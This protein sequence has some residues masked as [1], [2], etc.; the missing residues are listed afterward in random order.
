M[1]KSLLASIAFVALSA[2]GSAWAAD[3]PVK[4]RPVVPAWTWNGC[5]VGLNVGYANARFRKS[6]VVRVFPNPVTFA[7]FDFD[8][9]GAAGGAQIGCNWQTGQTVFGIETD[10][11]VTSIEARR[12]FDNAFFN[13][14]DPDLDTDVHSSLRYFGTVR[15]RLGWTVTPTT[16][17][18][19]T[20]GFAYGRV[21]SS[22]QILTAAGAN[23]G[24][25]NFDHQYHYG[26]AVGAGGEAKVAENFTAKLEYLYV[27]L[28]S[29]DYS[30]N[31]FPTS[32]L[33][34]G[35]KQRVDV[36]TIRLGLNYQFDW[37]KPVVAKY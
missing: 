15:G 5:Y 31:V 27:D 25:L 7:D 37:Y 35:W 8:D 17:L 33:T 3:M 28:G 10:I 16:L 32:G 22:F 24:F 1:K 30:F 6:D 29:K 12:Y 26:Y 20:G 13:V 11:Q 14:P 9:D 2:G 4:V 19:V 36:H 23:L 18:Y 34:F 21:D